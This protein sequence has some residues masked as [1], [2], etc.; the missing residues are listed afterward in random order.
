MSV[1]VVFHIGHLDIG[2]FAVY[3]YMFPKMSNLLTGN[4]KKYHNSDILSV[5]TVYLRDK[6]RLREQGP[7]YDVQGGMLLHNFI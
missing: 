1:G 4:L 6:Q 7:T 5:T 2:A 3:P